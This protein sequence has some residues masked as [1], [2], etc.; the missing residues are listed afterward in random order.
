MPAAFRLPR[1]WAGPSQGM[2]V[3]GNMVRVRWENYDSPARGRSADASMLAKLGTETGGHT[4]PLRGLQVLAIRYAGVLFEDTA[5]LDRVGIG[6]E[7][8]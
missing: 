1:V 4:R 8:M 7:K 3:A 6:F 2:R 5:A